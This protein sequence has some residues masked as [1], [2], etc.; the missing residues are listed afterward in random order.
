MNAMQGPTGPSWS[1]IATWYD[2]LLAHGSGPHETAVACLLRL[3]P[4]VAGSSVLDIACGTGLATRALAGAGARTVTGTD[5]SP[6]MID[7]ARAR[8]EVPSAIT[9]RVD[10]AQVL[11]SCSDGEFDGVTC[12]LGLM[13]IPDLD[14]ALR[15]VRRVL[16]P[17]GWFVFVIGHPC[18]LAPRAETVTDN[19]GRSGRFIQEYRQERF[20]RSPNPKGVRRVGNYHRTLSTYLNALHKE[21]LIV[22]EAEEPLAEPLLAQRQPVYKKVPIFLAMRA[23]VG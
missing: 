2:Q 5:S 16:K 12:Q 19:L 20:W 6:A 10:D 14:A 15:S 13:D 21:D 11:A 23:R 22:E 8:T 3:A 1:D 4:D 9:Y 7:L 17:G 18:F